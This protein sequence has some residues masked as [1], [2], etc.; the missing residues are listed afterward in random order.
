MNQKKA[1]DP[2]QI[3]QKTVSYNSLLIEAMF[4]ILAEKNVLTGEEVLE[5]I[6]KL[7]D[8]GLS[9]PGRVN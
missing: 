8:D 5:R 3:F 4:E 2:M 9:I 1:D 7:R 6:K